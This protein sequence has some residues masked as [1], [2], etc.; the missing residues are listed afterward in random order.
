MT[1][2]HSTPLL[3]AE[4]ISRR[5]GKQVALQD[6]VLSPYQAPAASPMRVDN[7]GSRTGSVSKNQET[8]VETKMKLFTL[9]GIIVCV[10]SIAVP[11]QTVEN[12]VRQELAPATST[13]KP[14]S[15]IE[16]VIRTEH[17]GLFAAPPPLIADVLRKELAPQTGDIQLRF[18]LG[19]ESWVPEPWREEC[20]KTACIRIAWD[21]PAKWRIELQDSN[22]QVF[23]TVIKAMKIT[24]AGDR[25]WCPWGCPSDTPKDSG[26]QDALW[27]RTVVDWHM[28]PLSFGQTFRPE[29]YPAHYGHIEEGSSDPFRSEI[30][31]TFVWRFNKFPTADLDQLVFQTSPEIQLIATYS[32][33]ANRAE[34]DTWDK[35]FRMPKPKLAWGEL[36]SI[37]AGG[38]SLPSICTRTSYEGNRLLWQT[39]LIAEESTCNEPSPPELFIVNESLPLVEEERLY[40]PGISS[41]GWFERAVDWAGAVMGFE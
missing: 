41:R 26:Y 11:A 12:I 14:P 18:T 23:R 22:R 8:T 33:K 2:T 13:D 1:T 40:P 20:R 4:S 16:D 39:E 5:Y 30:R 21:S 17:A 31:R 27:S 7:S 19:D 38:V 37:G 36:V 9:C 3:H 34:D 32:L 25:L 6:F 28:F 24:E 10:A 29:N 35:Y 15:T